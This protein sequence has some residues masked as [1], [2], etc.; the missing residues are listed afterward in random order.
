MRKHIKKWCASLAL[1]TLLMGNS[2]TADAA[3][4]CSVVKTTPKYLYS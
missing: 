3:D 4:E 1:I 2:P